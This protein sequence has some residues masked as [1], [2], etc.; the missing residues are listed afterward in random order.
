MFLSAIIA[1]TLSPPLCGVFLRPSRG[2]KRGPIGYV[3]R[4][5]DKVCDAYGAAVAR[6]VRLSIS[7]IVMVVIAAVGTG[8]LLKVTPSRK[9]TKVRISW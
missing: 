9:T 4:G 8:A 7:G 2:P 6:I 5:I 1:L 3:M